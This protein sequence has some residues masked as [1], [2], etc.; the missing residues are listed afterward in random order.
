MSIFFLSLRDFFS[1]SFLKFTLIPFGV[2]VVLFSLL[3]YFGFSYLQ[4]LVQGIFAKNAVLAWF[5]SFGVFSFFLSMISFLASLM[6]VLYLSVFVSLIISTF[7]N[8]N[9]IHLVFAKHYPDLVK[10]K[11]TGFMTIIYQSIKVLIKSL[12]LLIIC[13]I[14]LFIP[15]LN[16]L[17]F[18][19]L[20]Y[21]LY[22]S[23]LLID[24]TSCIYSN[25]E[26]K[27]FWKKG[28][29][30]YLKGI[31]ALFYLLSSLP[32]LGLILQGFFTIYLAHY[33]ARQ[34]LASI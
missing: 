8:E 22:S 6:L 13:I 5:Y 15:M 27:G 29:S 3:C 18:Y 24:T 11:S 14:L 16:L 20:F 32:F 25:E 7:F 2:S 21:Y 12:G 33:F 26:F 31:L 34:K 4:D 1:K 28:S 19:L 30:L 10:P 23:F 9:M 17:G